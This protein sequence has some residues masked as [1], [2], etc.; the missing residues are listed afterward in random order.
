MHSRTGSAPRRGTPT[1]VPSTRPFMQDLMAGRLGPLD[2]AQLVVQHHA[3]YSVLEA[4][5]DASTDPAIAPLLL[6][7]AAPAARSSLPTSR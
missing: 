7:G 1:P 5:V 2:Y 3:I 6:A 4:A